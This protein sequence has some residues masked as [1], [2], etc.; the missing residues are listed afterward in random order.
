[1][2][3]A[4]SDVEFYASPVTR[5]TPHRLREKFIEPDQRKLAALVAETQI[6]HIGVVVDEHPVVIPVAVAWH[7]DSLVLHGSTGSG[8]LAV[9][10]TG[11]DV[12]VTL[13][14]LDGLVVARS[15]FE[16][17]MHYR[18][19][20]LFGTCSALDGNE[21]A[22]ALDT[23]TE[24]LIPGRVCEV[25]RPTSRELAATLVVRMSITEWSYKV[26]DRWPDDP[27]EDVDG[28]SWAGVLPIR[29]SYR[30]P[31]PAPDLRDGISVPD[32][33]RNLGR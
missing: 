6:A 7:A 21:K 9:V 24:A 29:R 13:T 5:T 32:S 3:T 11:A 10:A 25:R 19:A 1:L 15:A 8:W 17:S 30:A 2:S 33:V 16:S 27:A 14:S 26:S 22:T 18:S 20:V 31:R 28:P 4:L 12:C 23:L